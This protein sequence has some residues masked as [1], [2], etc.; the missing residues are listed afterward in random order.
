M[1]DKKRVI[2][3]KFLRDLCLEITE[4]LGK[5]NLHPIEMELVID[6]LSKII[7]KMNEETEDKAFMLTKMFMKKVKEMKDFKENGK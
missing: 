6:E 1:E 5:Y 3:M 2:D 7:K 4:V